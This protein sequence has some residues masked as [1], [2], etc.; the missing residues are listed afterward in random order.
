MSE[1]ICKHLEV[2][3]NCKLCSKEKRE[4]IEIMEENASGI[5]DFIKRANEH[6]DKRVFIFGESDE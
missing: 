3:N 5:D 4:A 1:E 2:K 6:A